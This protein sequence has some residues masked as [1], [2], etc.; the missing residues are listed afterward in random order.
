M[1]MLKNKCEFVFVNCSYPRILVVISHSQDFLNGVCTN[2]IHMHLKGL[3]L[4]G[5]SK[6]SEV[7]RGDNVNDK[8]L[9]DR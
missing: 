6:S 9:N 7:E 5:V 1:L 4:Y 3:K 8:V 2:I